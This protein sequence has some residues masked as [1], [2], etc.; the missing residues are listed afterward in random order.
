MGNIDF[1]HD[2]ASPSP[3][4]A[5]L[6]L[7]IPSHITSFTLVLPFATFISS[8]DTPTCSCNIPC[9]VLLA[10]HL[11]G[12]RGPFRSFLAQEPECDQ[13]QLQSNRKW[14][15]KA[16][17]PKP[18]MLFA[19]SGRPSPGVRAVQHSKHTMHLKLAL[20]VNGHV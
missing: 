6:T 13:L 10:D 8:H 9:Q 12:S 1:T 11:F 4:P 14:S 20:L 18:L 5:C 16:R 3:A 17:V 7:C 2:G 19:S 15:M